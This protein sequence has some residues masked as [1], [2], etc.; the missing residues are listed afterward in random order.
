[1]DIINETIKAINEERDIAPLNIDI[2]TFLPKLDQRIQDEYKVD[3]DLYNEF[4]DI[5]MV[6]QLNNK[7]AIFIYRDKDSNEISVSLGGPGERWFFKNEEEIPQWI[8]SRMKLWYEEQDDLMDFLNK[9]DK[10]HQLY[11]DKYNE[12]VEHNPDNHLEYSDWVDHLPMSYRDEL[13]KS[14]K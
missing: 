12:Y 10:L 13:E 11:V 1:M 4:G 8:N 14:I 5:N 9:G 7:L 3:M 2:N 6:S